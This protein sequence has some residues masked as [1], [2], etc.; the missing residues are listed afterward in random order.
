MKEKIIIG[1]DIGGTKCAISLAKIYDEDIHILKK[2]VMP[3]DREGSP[4]EII[5][6]FSSIIDKLLEGTDKLTSIGISCGGPLNSQKGIIMSPPNLPN[7]NNI[8]IVELLH[9]R[10]GVSVRLQNDANACALA[11]WKYG[12]GRGSE[13]MIFLTF[14]TGLG[15]GLIL[16][17]KLYCGTTD[18]EG[19]VGH[20]R[21]SE[22]GPAGYGKQGSFEGFCSG[23][24]LAQLGYTLGLAAYQRNC[25][26]TY[27]NP[28]AA[29][30]D[31]SAKTIA[32]AAEAG[33]KIAIEVYRLCGEYLGRGLSILIDILNP[34]KIIIGSIF[35]RSKEL[36]WPAA[37]AIIEQEALFQSRSCCEV[38]AAELGEKLGDYAAL[39]TAIYE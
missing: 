19:E 26:P 31:I 28:K 34:Q 29:Y 21:L 36:I 6:E 35:K 4:Y 15:A 33:D 18:M 9:K 17:G 23:S 10:Y 38:L 22:F 16:N 30:Q 25:C 1:V 2:E 13:N 11:E 3:T 32:E 8:P 7:W 24:G 39:A 5:D 14:G 37:K 12:A 27:F 20:V